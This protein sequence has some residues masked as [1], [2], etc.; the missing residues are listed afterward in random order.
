MQSRVPDLLLQ[1]ASEIKIEFL[2]AVAYPT[3]PTR[4]SHPYL[5]TALPLR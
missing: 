5:S 4:R 1:S 3:S 2:P